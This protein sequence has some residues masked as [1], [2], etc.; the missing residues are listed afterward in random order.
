MQPILDKIRIDLVL[1]TFMIDQYLESSGKLLFYEVNADIL[2]NIQTQVFLIIILMITYYSNYLV[3]KLLRKLEYQQFFYFGQQIAKF[4][5]KVLKSM[6][7]FKRNFET[8]AF[9]D[10]LNKNSWDF[11]FMAFLQIQSK[12]NNIIS[13][14]IAYLILYI[15]LFLSSTIFYR[16]GIPNIRNP[17]QLWIS[18]SNQIKILKKALFISVL[19]MVQQNQKLQIMLLTFVCQFYLI[20]LFIMKPIKNIIDQINTMALEISSFIFCFSSAL[21]LNDFTDK[22]NYSI[23]IQFAWFQIGMLLSCL[24]INFVSQLC[25]IGVELKRLQLKSYIIPNKI[26][27]Q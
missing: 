25:M 9:Q 20:Y 3:I 21:Y 22:L 16:I 13:K 17:K 5:M 1:T 11:L 10:F 14:L 18:K 6:Q 12:T 15:S 24:F 19:V 23:Q 7:K 8:Y 27:C 26:R 2:C 4:F